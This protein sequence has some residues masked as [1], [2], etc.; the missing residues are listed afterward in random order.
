MLKGL[1]RFAQPCQFM[2]L[3]VAVV[4]IG[5]GM[6]A[7][8]SAASRVT[9]TVWTSAT[10]PYPEIQAK[11]EKDF[12][13]KHPS[14]DVK[15]EY[16]DWAQI[17]TKLLA[18]LAGGVT[19]DMVLLPTRYA[20]SFIEQG[21][22]VPVDYKALGLSSQTD[23]A[24]L[25]LPGVAGALDFGGKFYFLPTELTWLGLYYNKS[26][27]DTAG[28]AKVPNTWEEVGQLGGKLTRIGPGGVERAGLALC[29]WGPFTGFWF[30]SMMRSLGEDWLKDGKPNFSSPRSVAALQVFADLYNRYRAAIPEFESQENFEAGK[31]GFIAGL[32][33]ALAGLREAIHDSFELRVAEYPH[34]ASGR[35]A[36]IAYAWGYFVLANSK[37]QAEAWKVAYEFTSPEN[38][39]FWYKTGSL[40][41]P[42]GDKWVAEMAQ[43]D[44]DMRTL[45]GGL[46][47][48]TMELAHPRFDDII[49]EINVACND[50]VLKGLG[51][52]SAMA[53]LDARLTK[54]LKR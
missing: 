13:A 23:F 15:L 43:K 54:I 3:L 17:Q 16:I 24:K 19:P 53:E 41:V 8:A 10:G 49:R 5:M 34:L 21:L 1:F 6:P 31:I 28:I 46:S 12:E 29:R 11:L 39:P 32:S 51:V 42:R 14:I 45:L 48:A 47:V 18:G 52:A 38:A 22:L 26:M 25:F 7:P 35:P 4:G 36:N 20:P 27:L 40:F 37:H 30:L 9:V 44:A 2:V 50:I 33:M